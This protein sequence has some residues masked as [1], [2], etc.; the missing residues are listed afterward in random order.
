M[1]AHAWLRWFRK[2]QRFREAVLWMDCCMDFQQSIP[3]QEVL[4]RPQLGTGIPGPAFIGLAAH[5]KK[6]LE[7]TMADGKVHGVF[8]WTLLQGLRGGASDERGQ[9]T[10]E[11]LRTFLYTVM[12]EFLP[13]DARSA[14][15]ID[16]Q[17]FVRADQGM[18]FRVFP[19]G[20]ST[21]SVSR[22][23]TPRPTRS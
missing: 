23:R 8:T 10:G 19:T 5:T 2:A 6:A 1:Y 15:L 18:V 22:C 13:E 20:R 21:R 4:M 17:P 11:S 12:P 16:L 14:G 7:R 9:V 3:V